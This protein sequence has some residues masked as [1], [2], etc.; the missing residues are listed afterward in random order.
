[1][2]NDLNIGG[3]LRLN[4]TLITELPNDLQ[5]KKSIYVDEKQKN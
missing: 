1:L 3:A 2:S 4:N 5:V